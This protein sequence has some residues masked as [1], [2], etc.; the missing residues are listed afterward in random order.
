[1]YFFIKKREIIVIINDIK[2]DLS[3]DKGSK[4]VKL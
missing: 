1:M 4:R 2:Y 3:T